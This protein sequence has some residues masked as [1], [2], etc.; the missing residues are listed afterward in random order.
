METH[1][2]PRTSHD[3]EHIDY[4]YINDLIRKEALSCLNDNSNYTVESDDE[5]SIDYDYISELVE[6]E[7]RYHFTDRIFEDQTDIDY[8]SEEVEPID[9]DYLSTLVERHA[10]Y[11]LQQNGASNNDVLVDTPQ[12]KKLASG[13]SAKVRS[14]KS[15]SS[16]FRQ[17]NMVLP[18]IELYYRQKPVTVQLHSG[19]CINIV[20]ASFAAK[21][22]FPVKRI[23]LSTRRAL[24]DSLPASTVGEVHV[25]LMCSGMPSFTL[26]AVVVK[27]HGV[28]VTGGM[29][30]LRENNIGIDLPNDQIIIAG[31]TRVH[32][33]A[34]QSQ[35]KTE[36]TNHQVRRVNI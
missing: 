17:E 14:V 4:D 26:G 22:G 32:Y 23:T 15:K 9:Y 25:K 10:R 2:G 35:I 12:N 34:C 21:I 20:D 27:D 11:S 18:F 31:S 6:A 16:A 1:N 28:D 13:R 24:G 33:G 30:F 36:R 8:I 7:V 5:E 3:K 19:S 29:P